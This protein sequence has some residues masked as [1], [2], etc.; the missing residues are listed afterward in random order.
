MGIQGER[1]NT[2]SKTFIYSCAVISPSSKTLLILSSSHCYSDQK[3]SNS[4]GILDT[5]TL[6]PKAIS[7]FQRVQSFSPL[8]QAGKRIRGLIRSV[9]SVLPALHALKTH[10]TLEFSG[11]SEPVPRPFSHILFYNTFTATHNLYL[12]LKKNLFPN[13][14]SNGKSILQC[15]GRL[16]YYLPTLVLRTEIKTKLKFPVSARPKPENHSLV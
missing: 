8:T 4:S 15:T 14:N 11:Y 7:P 2:H 3:D 9:C 12:P 10:I 16:C 1:P 13:G 6:I 5:D